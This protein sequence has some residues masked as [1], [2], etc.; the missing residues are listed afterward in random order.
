MP[1]RRRDPSTG[2]YAP[3]LTPEVRERILNALA[4]GVPPEV[5]A[6]YAGVV[7]ST[8]NRWLAQGRAAI[9][10]ANG[11]LEQ[12]LAEDEYAAFARDVDE[13]IARFVVAHMAEITSMG[14]SGGEG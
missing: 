5:A 2:R 10:A 11:N 9:V 1:R 6:A 14:R 4:S 3:K 12:V 7:R 13:A 8:Y